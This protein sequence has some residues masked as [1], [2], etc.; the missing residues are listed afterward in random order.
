MTQSE[1][2]PV[3]QVEVRASQTIVSVVEGQV[4][5]Q[6]QERS[7]SKLIRQLLV[8]CVVYG[9]LL[10]IF[11][12]LFVVHAAPLVFHEI[13]GLVIAV[14]VGFHVFLLRSF[15]SFAASQRQPFF[16]YRDFVLL[17]LAISFV[18]AVFSGIAFSKVLFRDLLDFSIISRSNWRQI[19]TL[20]T[21]YLLVFIGLHLGCYANKFYLWLSESLA[22]V[23]VSAKP[24]MTAMP[25]VEAVKRQM[26]V[27]Q[28]SK[29]IKRVL[30]AALVLVSLNGAVQ[31]VSTSF[32][33]KLIGRRAFSFY[34]FERT[35]IANAV[36]QLS[37]M[38][39]FTAV[40][41]L[42]CMLL[43]NLSTKKEGA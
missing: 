32:F 7:R 17:G 15:F 13:F 1:Q 11:A 12:F 25:M 10:A 38:F 24:D 26:K 20:A 27:A 28:A 8:S 6:T 3:D 22:Q 36:D 40:S 34:D 29:W 18:V 41:I 33:G 19:H 37:I 4:A 2:Q 42:I 43:Q 9:L 35:W 21:S 14:V 16:I 23:F 39:L 5:P 30:I 31:F